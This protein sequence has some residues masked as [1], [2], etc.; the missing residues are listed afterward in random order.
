MAASR[1]HRRGGPPLH[2]QLGELLNTHR[3]VLVYL[4]GVARSGPW[5]ARELRHP[6]YQVW[7]LSKEI[8]MLIAGLHPEP[9][10]AA[11]LPVAQEVS[12][13]GWFP[14][15]RETMVFPVA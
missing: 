9:A 5:F 12:E 2:D 6:I 4:P 7:H 10:I 13:V 3:H 8:R 1:F 11:D 14:V 15:R